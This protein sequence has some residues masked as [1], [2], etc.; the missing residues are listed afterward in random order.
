MLVRFFGM[1][2]LSSGL[3]IVGMVISD[4]E[5]VA[6]ARTPTV[7]KLAIVV[8]DGDGGYAVN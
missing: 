5:P 8:T 1:T 6:Y 4:I 2:L 3:G 7:P